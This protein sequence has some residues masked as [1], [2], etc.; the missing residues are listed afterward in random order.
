MPRAHHVVK[1]ATVSGKCVLPLL[2][3]AYWCALTTAFLDDFPVD[4]YS[5]RRSYKV[6]EALL[7]TTFLFNQ[8][9]NTLVYLFC[10]CED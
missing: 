1:L 8:I 3:W 2:D 4:S 7:P 9:S 6:L 10:H 5:F